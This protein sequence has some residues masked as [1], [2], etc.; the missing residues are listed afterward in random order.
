MKKVIVFL[1]LLFVCSCAPQ[2]IIKEQKPVTPPP[3]AKIPTQAMEEPALPTKESVTPLFGTLLSDV[4]TSKPSFN[5]GLGEEVALY[6]HLS[7]PAKITVQVYDPDHGLIRMLAAEKNVNAGEQT[8]IWDGKDLDGNLV[9][10]EAYFFTIIAEDESGVKEIYDPTTFSGG[11]GH[12]IT[13]ADINSQ[14]QTITYKMPEMG[15]VMIRMGIQGGPLMNQLVDWKPR[16][17]GMITEYWNGKDKDNLVDLHNHAKFKMIVT[18]FT[19]P[20][21]SVIAFGNKTQTYRDYKKSTAERS[22]KI[23][24]PS[25]VQKVSHHYGLPRTMDY[26]PN[27][28]MTFVN[29]QGVDS[30]GVTVLNDKTLVKVELDEQDKLIFQNQQFE[31]CFF[32]NGE[33]YAED[34]AGYTPFN[35]VWDLSSVEEGEH[36]L[37][38]NI[39]GFKDQ[40]GVLSR[41]VKVVK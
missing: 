13:T 37:T 11:A 40:I 18:Y 6:Y 24:R 26:S 39:S 12:D 15:R 20:E 19:L 3:L 35:W 33:F 21:N 14:S 36:V 5:P 31:I 16:V 27:V 4:K 25:A 2:Q 1:L 28:N 8:I 30:D 23:K 38:V 41:K 17:K 7:K 10:D 29:A 22:V 32:L 34:E 9:P